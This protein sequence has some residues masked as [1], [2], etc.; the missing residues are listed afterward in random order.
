MSAGKII[1]HAKLLLLMEYRMGPSERD[2]P[3]HIIRKEIKGFSRLPVHPGQLVILAV[4]IV[5]ARLGVASLVASIN[6]RRAL[7]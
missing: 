2:Q 5:I 6:Q 1:R 4:D 3:F 7:A